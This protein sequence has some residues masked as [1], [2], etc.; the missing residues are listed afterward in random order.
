MKYVEDIINHDISG[1][2]ELRLDTFNDKRGEIWS[3][4]EDCDL[5]PNFVEDKVTISTKGVLR[6]LHGDHETSKLISCLYGEIFLAVVDVRDDS[7][8]YGNI[9]VFNLSDKKPTMILVP[10]GCLN[11]HM[12]LS[13]KCV[14]FYKWT[15]KYSGPESQI[16]VKWDDPRLNIKWPSK[17]PILSDR[18]LN[19]GYI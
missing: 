2:L 4:Y 16:T 3:I 9:K 13:D 8:T 11:G 10:A 7:K 19:A 12:C 18:D 15:K 14:F 5:L 17:S 1:L 6:G